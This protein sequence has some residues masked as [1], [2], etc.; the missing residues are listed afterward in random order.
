MKSG[1]DAMPLFLPDDLL[2]MLDDFLVAFSVANFV[3][4]SKKLI[5]I[6]QKASISKRCHAMKYSC[7]KKLFWKSFLDTILQSRSLCTV[8]AV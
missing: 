8:T 3:P 6:V 4:K 2:K 7:P 1:L 5:L